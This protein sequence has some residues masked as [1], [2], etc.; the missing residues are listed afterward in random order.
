MA[1][2]YIDRRYFA[3]NERKWVSFESSPRL[4]KTKKDIYG[5]CVP[6]ITNLYE[7]LQAGK[8]EIR[9]SSAFRCWKIVVQAPDMDACIDFLDTLEK[10]TP[11]D[12]YVRGRFGSG[13][14]SK[15]TKV[16]V[17]NADS[18]AEKDE[19]RH[20]VKATASQ[21]DPELPVTCHKACADL[22]HELL[23]DWRE[24]KEIQPIRKPEA[25]RH[26]LERIRKVLFWERKEGAEIDQG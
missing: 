13:D 12:M 14:E 9:L 11:E 2:I 5:K 10:D 24:W 21:F 25:V 3:G 17:F 19:I 8:T 20:R 23:G 18:D 16:I 1:R 6:C 22:Y 26:I 4:E 7:Q 15:S